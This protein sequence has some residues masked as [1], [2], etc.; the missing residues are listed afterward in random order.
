MEQASRYIKVGIFALLALAIGIAIVFLIG[1]SHSIFGSTVT[2]KTAFTNVG[3][4][5]RGAPVRIGGLDVGTVTAVE[6]G[7]DR[8]VLVTFRVDAEALAT[9]RSDSVVRLGNKGLLGDR[10]LDLDTGTA[11][12]RRIQAG[13]T[14]RSEEPFDLMGA[15]AGLRTRADGVLGNAQELTGALADPEFTGNVRSVAKN[16]ATITRDVA[17]SNGTAGRLL[18]D[19]QLAADIA[20]ATQGLSVATRQVTAA[21]ADVRAITRDLRAMMSEIRHG[22]SLL[23]ELVYGDDGGRLLTELTATSSEVRQMLAAIREG[24]GAVHE[25][26]Y[27]DEGGRIVANI[28]EATESVREILDDVQAG[29]GTIGGLLVDPSIYEDIKRLIGDLERNDILRALVR[30][31]ITEDER[32]RPPRSPREQ[33]GDDRTQREGERGGERESSDGAEQD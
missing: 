18:R 20:S 11:A 7:A 14:L 32:R 15:A 19:E 28:A 24:D 4:L 10:L 22:D 12:G 29:R 27:G 31:S 5:K 8:R 21:T 9:L 6:Y 3:G 17:E 23:H 25:L 26:V 16:L 30:Y 1:S 13:A 33:R 2:L